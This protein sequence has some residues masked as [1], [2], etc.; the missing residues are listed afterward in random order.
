MTIK[1]LKD[2]II[3]AR[4]TTPFTFSEVVNAVYENLYDLREDLFKKYQFRNSKTFEIVDISN[5]SEDV[6]DKVFKS[7]IIIAIRKS[8]LLA[9]FN[10]EVRQPV[11]ISYWEV[12]VIKKLNKMTK[13]QLEE[14]VKNYQENY[15]KT[16]TSDSLSKLV[17]KISLKS[18][19]ML[20]ELPDVVIY[21][22]DETG[23]TFKG[24]LGEFYCSTYGSMPLD[25]PSD[26]TPED[27][28]EKLDSKRRIDKAIFDYYDRIGKFDF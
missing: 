23:W 14:I 10:A 7:F 3:K 25:N 9:E 2:F 8:G 13:D 26:R 24:V 4:K 19:T 11:E 1:E 5:V 12:E 6:K 17:T 16:V 20:E 27:Y 15:E 28:L 18:E 21:L 22:T